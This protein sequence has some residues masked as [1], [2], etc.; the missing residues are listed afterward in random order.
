MLIDLKH[1]R[2][3]YSS[4]SLE[5]A[6]APAKP[7]ELFEQ[8]MQEAIQAKLP[9]PN[10]MTLATCKPDGFPAARVVLLKGLSEA[11]FIFYTNYNSNKGQELAAN[12]RA[13]LVFLWLEL[14]RQVRIEGKVE[15]IA[16]S[17]SETYFQSRPKGS[18]IGAAASPQ[19][20]VIAG[21]EV[22][23]EN[24]KALELKYAN[25]EQLPRPAH[26]GGYIVKPTR[27][28]FWKGRASRLHDRLVYVK[29]EERLGEQQ[30]KIERL[31]P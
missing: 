24:V 20:A 15:K 12:P 3:E 16:P 1:L 31:A 30:W 4:S 2:E 18:Q 11:G 7:I 29:K 22:L 27:I 8:W 28:E 17:A 13:A 9:E 21:R 5:L 25:Q 26:W 10:A 6:D 14:Q 19:S 23:E